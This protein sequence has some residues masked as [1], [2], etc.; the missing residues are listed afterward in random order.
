MNTE[1]VTKYIKPIFHA[2]TVL[3]A[4]LAFAN[5]PVVTA[6]VP[7]KY[8]QAIAAASAAV[9]GILHFISRFWPDVA[10]AEGK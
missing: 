3:S 6:F 5:T 1:A 10:A 4:A 2:L 8:L 7:E 9:S